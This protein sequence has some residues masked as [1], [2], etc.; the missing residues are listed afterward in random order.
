MNVRTPPL[1]HGAGNPSGG[2]VV[3]DLP[4]IATRRRSTAA[5]VGREIAFLLAASVF[6]AL[7][8]RISILLPFSPVPVTGQTL[9]V[10]LVG[11]LYG[12]RRGAL[13]VLAYLAEGLG[14]APV[15]AGGA[16]GPAVL[17]GPTGGYLVGFLPAAAIAGWLAGA[18]RP[19]ALRLAGLVLASLV[20]YVC[21]VSWLA[22]ATGMGVPLALA[23]GMV[24]FLPGDTLK[25]LLAAGVTP[26][27]ATLLKRLDLRPW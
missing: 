26:A 7:T 14:G 2:R 9:G 18:R 23:K 12:P 21:G 5:L 11:A 20:I 16:A 4:L 6:L 24:P 22:Y 27:G 13:A 3:P 8:A 1:P 19:V 15:F 10:L 17:F 25:L